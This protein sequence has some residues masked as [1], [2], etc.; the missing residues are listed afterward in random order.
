MKTLILLITLTLILSAC[1]QEKI[2]QIE[3]ET[4]KSEEKVSQYIEEFQ[5]LE[6]ERIKNFEEIESSEKEVKTENIEISFEKQE[7]IDYDNCIIDKE[8]FE[9]LEENTDI[10]NYDDFCIPKY[11]LIW[12]IISLEPDEIVVRSCWEDNPYTLQQFNKWDETFVYNISKN[13]WNLCNN[14]EF[15]F[16]SNWEK[17]KSENY[18]FEKNDNIEYVF[19]NGELVEIDLSKKWWKINKIFLKNNNINIDLNDWRSWWPYFILKDNNKIYT[20]FF[21][22]FKFEWLYMDYDYVCWETDEWYFSYWREYIENY[23]YSYDNRKLIS[24]KDFNYTWYAWCDFHYDFSK[25]LYISLWINNKIKINETN[26]DD[27]NFIFKNI[28]FYATNRYDDMWNNHFKLEVW[29]TIKFFKNKYT[30]NYS[31]LIY[32]KDN[33]LL[34]IEH[35]QW[36]DWGFIMYYNTFINWERQ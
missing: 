9:I 27:F 12:T 6:E 13:N 34:K 28:P 31:F 7:L 11:Q 3:I 20:Q 22:K 35:Q 33:N 16:F 30:W 18:F 15:S 14:F 2:W 24:M 17:I 1:N 4:E 26:I 29:D 21:D 25:E 36:M 5:I 8:K 23:W 19:E 32:D 10:F